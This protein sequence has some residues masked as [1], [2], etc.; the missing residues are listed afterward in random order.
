MAA[1][2]PSQGDIVMLDFT[3]QAGHEQA[4]RR[5]RCIM[6]LHQKNSRLWSDLR[7]KAPE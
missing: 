5:R 6:V 7:S 1:Y 2:Y 3:P 4:G